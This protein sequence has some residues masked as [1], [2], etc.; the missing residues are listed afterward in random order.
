MIILWVNVSLLVLTSKGIS[1]CTQHYLVSCLSQLSV[2]PSFII[3][4]LKILHDWISWFDLINPIPWFV[5]ISPI[6]QSKLISLVLWFGFISLD[7]RSFPQNSSGSCLKMLP[8]ILQ[9]LWL[10]GPRTFCIARFFLDSTF[11]GVNY[12]PKPKMT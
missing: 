11:A 12:V 10:V 9:I 7:P 6:L 8:I 5:L 4:H 3:E 2:F 1:R